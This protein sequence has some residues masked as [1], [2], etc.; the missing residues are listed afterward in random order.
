MMKIILNQLKVI[1]IIPVLFFLGCNPTPSP[2]PIFGPSPDP[3][4]VA[5]PTAT[6]TGGNFTSAQRVTLSCAT[7]GAAIRYTTNGTTPT[8]S[9]SRY[10]TPI[11]IDQTT[12][13]K[14]IAVKNGMNNSDVM[15]AVYTITIPAPPGDDV[16]L[17]TKWPFMVGAAAP[18]DAFTS[19]DGQYALLKHFNVLVAENDMKPQNIMP[20]I[21]PTT[22][23]GVYNWT[24][25]DKLVNYAKANNTK[26]RGHVLFWHSQT[27]DYLFDV[28]GNGNTATTTM[29]KDTLY[30]RMEKHI[31]TVFEKYRGDVLWWDVCNEVVGDNGQIRA[32]GSPLSGGSWY[33]KVMENSG[34]TGINRYEFVLKAF[35]WARHYAD[36]NGGTNVKLYLTDY[37]NEYSGPK[38]AEFENLIN[39]LITNN[40]PIDGVGFQCHI[41]WDWPSVT[42]I[43]NAIDKFAGKT[44]NDGTKLMTQ[45]TE[46]DMSLFSNSEGTATT[47]SD[48]V[49]NSRLTTQA[50]RYRQLFDIFKE[51][52]N[53]GKLDMV[54]VWGIADGHSWLNNRPYGRTDYPLFFDR[55][56]QPKETYRKLVE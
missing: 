27:P 41:K 4:K 51:K 55:N 33:T 47:L 34:L 23:P 7:E 31:K 11:N 24:N 40:A 9:S 35:Q 15:T 42:D 46:M 8:T 39:Y 14:A 44:R 2:D 21:K 30:D 16:I 56:Y 36:A 43:S 54:L 48:T 18:T 6:P 17:H 45:I 12:T 19:S 13:L 50:T 49:R 32:A 1:G 29:T 5:A 53:T 22:F 28:T 26:V 38:Q 3:G 25:A 52:Y 37:N 20:Y 10:T